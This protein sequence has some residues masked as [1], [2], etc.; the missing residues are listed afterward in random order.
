M[1]SMLDELRPRS[2]IILGDGLDDAAAF[3]ALGAARERTDLEL[4]RLAVAGSSR[5]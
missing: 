4:L 1:T 2:V 5:T 3:R